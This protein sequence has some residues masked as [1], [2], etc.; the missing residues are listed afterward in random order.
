MPDCNYTHKK[1]NHSKHFVDPEGTHTNTIEGQWSLIKKKIPTQKRNH[2][3][4]QEHLFEEIWRQQNNENLWG[5]LM[6]AIS[7]V[8]YSP[9][10]LGSELT[11]YDEAQ[12]LPKHYAT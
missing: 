1:V 9:V 10:D 12:W 7:F 5:A 3:V 4:L 2:H 8:K 11:F 6:E